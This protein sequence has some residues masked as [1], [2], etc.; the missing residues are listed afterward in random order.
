[1]IHLVVKARKPGQQAF[2]DQAA[3][4]R[5]QLLMSS[6]CL[7]PVL[8]DD[9]LPGVLRE[10]ADVVA[11]LLSIVFEKS[12]LSGEVPG[13]WKK[14]NVTPIFKKGRKEDLGKY[15][16][17]NLTSMPEKIAEQILLKTMLR[18]RQDKEGNQ[19]V[20]HVYTIGCA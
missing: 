18:H 13:D 17:V 1:M 11:K 9:I 19:N 16:L 8:M 12:W 5:L 10:T 14:G 3:F 15:R 2:F 4:D 20:Q 7:V 6:I